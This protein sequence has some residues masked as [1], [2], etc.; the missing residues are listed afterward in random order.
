MR[1]PDN[2]FSL[3]LLFLM[4]LCGV[5]LIVFPMLSQQK[6]IADDDNLYAILAQEMQAAIINDPETTEVPT[7]SETE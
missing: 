7:I 6:E 2:R 5:A 4:F 3:V 1:L